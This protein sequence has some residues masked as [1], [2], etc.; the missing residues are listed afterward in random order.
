[1]GDAIR[2]LLSDSSSC[3]RPRQL[4]AAVAV[5]L[6]CGLLP[7]TSL[8]FWLIGLLCST[9]PIHLPLAAAVCLL[10]SLASI[11]IAELAGHLGV[12]SLTHPLLVDIWYGL[13]RLPWVPWLALNNSVVH[14]S[15]L[16]GLALLL[17]VYSLTRL[18]FVKL[19]PDAGS[20]EGRHSDPDFLHSIAASVAKA[21]PRVPPSQP[22]E[23]LIEKSMSMLAMQSSPPRVATDS[24]TDSVV[25]EDTC[26]E[27]QS[28]LATCRGEEAQ[29]LSTAQVARRAAQVAEFVDDL[30]N[31]CLDD[32]AA[33]TS[34]NRSQA[35]NRSGEAVE[36]TSD[37]IDRV[38]VY[39]DPTPYQRPF[40]SQELDN[41][42]SSRI[43]PGPR[44]PL[45]EVD[46]IRRAGEPPMAGRQHAPHTWVVRDGEGVGA[47]QPHPPVNRRS[48]ADVAPEET[49]RYLLHHLKAIKDK[50]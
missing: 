21:S 44:S 8:L 31:S 34:T 2:G 35:S 20:G 27:L 49:L 24:V 16:I 32:S 6:L 30:L 5:G 4:A 12:A 40:P 15:L 3:H 19:L 25:D 48:M 50:V 45:R 42:P 18:G 22:V 7:K 26:S 10:G 13:D 11:P 38:V 29:S 43:S 1:M 47:P 37:G 23:V 33:P 9:L 39:E 17:P 41:M 46:D 36:L 14:G 28:L